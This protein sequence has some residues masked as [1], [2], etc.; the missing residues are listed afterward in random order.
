[1]KGIRFKFI[2]LLVVVVLSIWAL[3]PTY[4]LYSVIPKQ[5]KALNDRLARATS[6]DESARVAV[7]IAELQNVKTDVHKRS[8]NLGLDIVGGMHL[9]LEVDKSKLSAEEARDAG[10]RALEVVRNRVDQF[11]VFEPV[12]QKVG[13]DRILIQL[14]GV[15][16]DRAKTLIGQTAQLKFQ[17]VQE[18]RA[19]YD[20][21]KTLDEKLKA[22]LSPDAARAGKPD[23][24]NKAQAD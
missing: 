14:P 2:G 22:G 15:D 11:G 4:R 24:L 18:E 20:A 21:L 8:L 7:D 6:S 10:D 5:E 9:T 13:R 19:T 12:I 16:R 17:L 23:S 3:H 1:M